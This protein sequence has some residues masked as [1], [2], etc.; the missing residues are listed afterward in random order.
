MKSLLPS[1]G[2]E[3]KHY[4][5]NHLQT[6]LD[7]FVDFRGVENCELVFKGLSLNSKKVHEQYLFLACAGS[8]ART[9]AGKKNKPQHGIAY[10]GE[11]INRGANCVAWEPTHELGSMPASCVVKSGPD[12]PL[13]RV[14][15]LHEK[16]GEIAAR[17]YRHPSRSLDVIGVTGTNG[18]TS[19]AHF[20]AQLVHAM[21]AKNNTD[22]C[23]VIGTLGNG[24]Y[25]E[26][27]KST[28]TTPDAVTLQALV[29][30]FQ[31]QQA[32][33][34]VMEVSS[35]ALAQGRVN[36]IEFDTAIFTNLSRDHL[37]YHGDMKSYADEK[38]KL[39][40]FP[41]LKHIVVNQDDEFSRDIIESVHSQ[42]SRKKI[43]IVSYSRSDTTADYYAQNICLNREGISFTLCVSE[44]TF[45]EHKSQVN[46]Q[47]DS[48]LVGDFNIE[49]L[50]AAVAVLNQRNYKINDIVSAISKVTTVPGRMEKIVIEHSTGHS[51]EH[52]TGHSTEQ[53]DEQ[54]V[55]MNDQLPLIVVDYAH[56]PDALDKGL[57]ALRAHT[58]GKLV[59]LFG[60]GGDRD[61]GKRALMAQVAEAQ[62]DSIMVTSDNPRTES[63]EQII[64]EI[65]AGFKNMNKILTETDREQAIKRTLQSIN[66][67]DV[68]LIA[69]KGHEDYQEINGERFPFSDKSCVLSFL[70]G[71]DRN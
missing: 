14:A 48:H 27:E 41:S 62:A 22:K 45:P 61:R 12:V 6:L 23:A 40:Q 64:S 43:D 16:V 42:S 9:S 52:S 33:T 71:G 17:F 26:L 20:I 70:S 68:L 18:K 56:T 36:G 5:H 39:F 1:V 35:H 2:Q 50:L 65:L 21:D 63:A 34:L 58:K 53:S 55:S 38:L 46:Y 15:V 28:H 60:C 49:N 32:G 3:K 51:T 54:I 10:A 44:N 66:A 57:K 59:C 7:G 19:T 67:D 24:I 25:G 8:S 47:I 11:A 37:D 13:I 69:G 29:A 30:D 4:P 31:S